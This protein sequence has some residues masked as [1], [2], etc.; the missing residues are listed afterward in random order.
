MDTQEFEKVLLEFFT[1]QATDDGG[2]PDLEGCKVSKFTEGRYLT[3][4]RGV[5]VRLGD[6]AEFQVTVVQ[7]RLS[8]GEDD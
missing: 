8:R 6:G 2:H 7:A 1:D 5:V 3:R 4:D